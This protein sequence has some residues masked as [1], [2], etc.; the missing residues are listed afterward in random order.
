M[1]V[2]TRKPANFITITTAG[3]H[4]KTFQLTANKE[5][6]AGKVY[7]Y[8]LTVNMS[9]ITLQSTTITDWEKGNGDNGESDNVT[10]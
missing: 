8:N 4:S 10:I 1:C 9:E 2:E 6:A 7:T 5:F 3:T